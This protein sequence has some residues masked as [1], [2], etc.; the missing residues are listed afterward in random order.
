MV[1]VSE[2][3]SAFSAPLE[4]FT[5]DGAVAPGFSVPFVVSAFSASMAVEVADVLLCGS[6]VVWVSRVCGSVVS[7]SFGT[8][9]GSGLS[10]GAVPVSAGLKVLGLVWDG[11]VPPSV[12][13]VS[14]SVAGEVS[15]A[16]VALVSVS[17]A[18]GVS[19]ASAGGLRVAGSLFVGVVLVL[20]VFSP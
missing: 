3:L 9:D 18:A 16:P 12:G 14:V 7:V 5:L 13:L 4:V 1:E 15:T 8:V 17:I 10:G 19:T 20:A 6:W 2:S 11:R